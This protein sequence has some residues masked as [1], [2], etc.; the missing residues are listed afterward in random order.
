M[1]N[2]KFVIIGVLCS[3]LSVLYCFFLWQIGMDFEDMLPFLI[4]IVT[5]NI[6]LIPSL[7]WS[8]RINTKK[9][10]ENQLQSKK[11]VKENYRQPKNLQEKIAKEI[12]D[13]YRELVD[14]KNTLDAYNNWC[15]DKL[16]FLM[17]I[18]FL[19]LSIT[20]LVIFLLVLFSNDD[21]T[22]WSYALLILYISVSGFG[23]Y[24]IDNSDNNNKWALWA[25]VAPIY[26]ATKF[27]KHLSKYIKSRKLYS[28]TSKHEV[29]QKYNFATEK[30][31]ALGSTT[32]LEHIILTA[33]YL[34]PLHANIKKDLVL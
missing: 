29:S 30:Y 12:S 19:I 28:K 22:F 23:V 14:S 11:E 8:A 5:L 21:V 17:A 16:A 7:I 6:I 4:P 24:L 3:L 31:T 1:K 18:F 20:L 13:A 34:S 25:T 33:K 2:L 27:F 10:M 32:D 9:L 26:F 15:N